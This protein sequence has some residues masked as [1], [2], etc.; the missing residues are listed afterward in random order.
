MRSD[1]FLTD[2]IVVMVFLVPALFIFSL[3]WERYG[4]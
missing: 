1:L 2:L 3:W 4:E